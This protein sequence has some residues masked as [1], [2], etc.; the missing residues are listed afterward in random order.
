V[1]ILGQSQGGWDHV[2]A[3]AGAAGKFAIFDFRFSPDLAFFS[4]TYS[5]WAGIA[6]GCFLTTATHGTDQLMVQRLLSARNEQQS[7]T[8]LLASWV[9]IFIQFSLFLLIGIMLFIFYTD[10]RLPPPQPPDRIYPQFI[11]Q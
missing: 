5:F 2:A 3:V 8:A 9:V 10:A 6:G 7:R 4:R 1:I 11:W